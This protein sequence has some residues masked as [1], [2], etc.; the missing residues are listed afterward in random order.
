MRLDGFRVTASFPAV[1]IIVMWHEF[2][3]VAV[4]QLCAAEPG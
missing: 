3:E 4:G 2:G 1:L